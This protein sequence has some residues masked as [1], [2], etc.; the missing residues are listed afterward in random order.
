VK[1]AE[2]GARFS[3]ALEGLGHTQASFI[4]WMMEHGDPRSLPALQR[5]IGR[6]ARGESAVSGEMWVLL[7]MLQAKKAEAA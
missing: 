7:G 5:Q 2:D 3:A 6:L 1:F 4:R